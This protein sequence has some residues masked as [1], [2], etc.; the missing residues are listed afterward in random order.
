MAKTKTTKR[1]HPGPTM[2]CSVC[3]DNIPES[4]TWSQHIEICV[5]K[6]KDSRTCE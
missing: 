4:T 2:I 3:K 6:E 1:K 5:K